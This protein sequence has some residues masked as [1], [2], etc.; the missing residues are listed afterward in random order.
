[1][2]M[3]GYLLKQAE[4]QT[5]APVRAAQ[6]LHESNALG[7]IVFFTPE[8]GR[9][10]TV[11]GLGVMVDELSIGVAALGQEVIVISP[12][13]E[14]NR[15][16][17]TGY[18]AKDPAGI[19]YKDNI[20]VDIN[21]GTTLGVHEGVVDGVRVV[22]LHNGD[23]FPSPYPDAQPAFTVQQLAVFGKGCLEYCCQRQ[24]IPSIAVTNDWF[25]GFTAAYAKVGHY[26]D[27][28]K[29]TSFI[30]ICHN[31]NEAYEG[32]IHLNHGDGDL[33][34]LH[35]LPRDWLI[36]P[37]WRGNVVNPSRC[38]IML[39]DQWATVSRSYRDEILHGSPLADLLKQKPQPFAHPNGIPIAERVRKLDAVA[40]DHLTAKAQLQKKY[41][42]LPALDDSVALF[43]FVGRVTTQKGVH[44][45]LDIAER[46]IMKSNYKVQFLV[47]GPANMREPYAADCAHKMW[48]LKAKYPACFWAAP[49][50]FFT[51]G[52]LVNRGADFGLMP[53]AFE[54]GGIV[55]HE[56]FVG[57][58][59]VVA[60]KTGGLKDSVLE[61]M[62]A[63]EEGTGYTFESYNA[64][65]FVFAMERAL[66][67]F[68]NKQKYNKLRENAFK[69][70]MPG[71]VVC[72]AWLAEFY[73]LKGKTFTDYSS[74]QG[75]EH[76][77]QS[78]RPQDYQPI[79][80]IQEIFGA[81]KQRETFA[82]YD[83]GA[84]EA[85]DSYLNDSMLELD[86]ITSAFDKA[87]FSKQPH[88]FQLHNRGPR[89]RHV[90]ICG[91]FDDWKVRHDMNF[92]PFTN[93]WFTTLHVK[94]GEEF[95]YKYI[96][97]GDNWVVNDEEA[98][99]K[100]SAGNVNNVVL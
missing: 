85:E 14:R 72:K 2:S 31:L 50:E 6:A 71:E 59:P 68:R 49:E 1:M 7:P 40:P 15:K 88:I 60:F 82:E 84:T 29:G 65:D 5:C 58:T 10:S 20:T 94:A 75:L 95:L 23:I 26:G 79:S 98:K 41:F 61:Y 80:I 22:F 21:G 99:R 43:A 36:D 91:S 46:I 81:D 24:C 35:K 55:Q 51:D 42:N 30:H 28:F 77:F 83:H 87:A 70:T 25:T 37:K 17:Q 100:D 56:F 54:P 38:A 90:Q 63:T 74:V 66:G 57:C 62:W 13:Y 11:G 92:D 18:L 69:G 97:N 19:H 27:T 53:S 33:G 39:S 73:R 67:T 3:T 47:G 16:G 93:Q 48:H 12:Y 76:T 32:R 78:W 52:A 64:D 44:L 96:I 86:V 89:H 34:A 9:W 4:G 8:L 45:I